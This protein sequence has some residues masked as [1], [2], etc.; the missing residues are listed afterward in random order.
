M[1]SNQSGVVM[2]SHCPTVP[3]ALQPLLKET[4]PVKLYRD[5]IGHPRLQYACSGTNGF[6]VISRVFLEGILYSCLA[7]D[8]KEFDENAL[9]R[10]N[11]DGAVGCLFVWGQDKCECVDVK[12]LHGEG[13]LTIAM[14]AYKGIIF[15]KHLSKVW[16]EY[17]MWNK[18]NTLLLDDSFARKMSEIY[19]ELS[20]SSPIFLD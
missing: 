11:P 9:S 20:S 12:N 2:M 18:S 14:H 15:M 16:H 17:P 13:I 6:N 19:G 7:E 1:P 4:I 5:P 10:E 8:R 3:L